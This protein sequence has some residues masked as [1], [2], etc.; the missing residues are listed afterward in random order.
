M[1]AAAFSALGIALTAA[2]KT[3]SAAPAVAN[4]VSLPLFFISGIFVPAENIP[5]WLLSIADV[6]P[7]KPLA[8]ALFT[9]FDPATAGFGVAVT[10]LVV[11]AA[12]G[13]AA[14]LLGARTFRWVPQRS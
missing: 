5:G 6:F 13:L 9:A 7:L 4:A 11:V 2:V 3:E 10:D 8:D 12:W 14:T 1:G